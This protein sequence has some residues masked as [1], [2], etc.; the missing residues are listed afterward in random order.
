MLPPN[1]I[2]PGE[3]SDAYPSFFA[4]A[5]IAFSIWGLIYLRAAHTLY[6]LGLFRKIDKNANDELL[7]KAVI[8]FS[9][10]SLANAAWIFSWYYRIIPLSM[11]LMAFLL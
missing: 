9:L 6:Q 8:V 4:P 2:T 11:G 3:V 7:R 10:S 5:G 1:G